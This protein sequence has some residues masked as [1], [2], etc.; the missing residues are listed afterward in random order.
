MY[1]TIFDFVKSDKNEEIIMK[2][3][4]KTHDYDVL[5]IPMVYDILL[6]RDNI[7]H[8]LDTLIY[9]LEKIE[10]YEKCYELIQLKNEM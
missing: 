4:P 8:T 2:I 6:T 7:E 3:I 9:N 1:D 10:D 5:Q